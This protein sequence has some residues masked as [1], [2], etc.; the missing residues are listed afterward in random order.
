MKKR[1]YPLLEKVCVILLLDLVVACPVYYFSE[2]VS[3]PIDRA[4]IIELASSPLHDILTNV[5]IY[6]LMMRNWMICFDLNFAL[7]QMNNQWKSGINKN[8]LEKANIEKMWYYRHRS[9]FGNYSWM[10]R[11]VAMVCVVVSTISVS[12]VIGQIFEEYGQSD[13]DEFFNNLL[14]AFQMLHYGAILCIFC[15]IYFLLPR[16]QDSL[17]VKGPLKK[18]N[19]QINTSKQNNFFGEGKWAHGEKT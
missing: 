18:K 9:T 14:I 12:I 8:Y 13:T 5:F 17:F 19:T 3:M 15:T 10:K 4:L 16:F 11:F 6:G 7:F 1:Y 2:T